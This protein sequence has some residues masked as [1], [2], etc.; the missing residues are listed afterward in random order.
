MP[1]RGVYVPFVCLAGGWVHVPGWFGLGHIMQ[2]LWKR[3]WM[4]VFRVQGFRF[5]VS[6]LKHLNRDA[7][8]VQPSKI[9]F[10]LHETTLYWG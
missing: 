5:P 9:L 8:V 2:G 10:F 3:K 6:G 7:E 1:G 4:L